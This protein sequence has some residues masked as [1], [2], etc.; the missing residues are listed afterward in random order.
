[1]KAFNKW[2]DIVSSGLFPGAA[3]RYMQGT[4]SANTLESQSME[5]WFGGQVYFLESV[6]DFK[7]I[8]TTERSTLSRSDQPPQSGG[9]A[10]L[11]E[12]AAVFDFVTIYRKEGN[13]E[14]E[15]VSLSNLIS[16]SGGPVYFIPISLVASCPH[17]N[18]ELSV[19]KSANSSL[20]MVVRLNYSEVPEEATPRVN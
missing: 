9:W 15:M 20:S 4:D 1:M 8:Y 5:Y 2:S 13:V 19:L 3:I 10:T 17:N 14:A 7:Q 12:R 18:V 6:E 11:H 16:D